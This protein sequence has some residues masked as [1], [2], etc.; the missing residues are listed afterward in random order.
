MYADLRQAFRTLISA[1]GFSAIV[2]LVLA[3][4]IGANTAIFSIVNG[5]LL[6]PLPFADA[7]RLVSVETTVRGRPDSSSYPDFLDWRAQAAS[8]DALAVYATTGTTLTGMGEA[9]GLPATVVSPELLSMLGV[10]PLR[11]RVFTADDDKPGAPRTVVS[12]ETSRFA[13]ANGS[14]FSSTPLTMLKIAVF[15]PMPMASTTIT[16]ALNP[17]DL[18]RARTA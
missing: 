8:F 12:T 11:G 1:K 5:V 13:S 9:K 14:G 15:A 10:A 4:G 2:V 18:T 17:G 7:D 6:K 16:S 3:L